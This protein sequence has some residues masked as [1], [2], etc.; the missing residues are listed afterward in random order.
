M[1]TLQPET[2][3]CQG[4]TKVY[5]GKVRAVDS[6]S[7][8][9]PSRGIFSLIGRNGAGKTTLVRILAT[10]LEP[11]SGRA[12]I[13]GM[14]VMNDAKQLRER[15][16]IVPQEARAISWMTPR[17]TVASYLLWRGF[18]Y[19]E[20]K[21]RA[22]EYLGKLGLEQFANRLNGSLSGGTKRK[23][24]VATVLASEAD[25]VFLDEPTTGLDPVS[26]RELWGTLKQLGSERFT[27]LTT[28]YLEEAEQ[29]AD[30]IGILRDGRLVA[31]GTL[32]ELRSMTEYQYSVRIPPGTGTRVSEG[33]SSVGEDGS[34]QVLLHEDDAFRVS[35]RLLE[36]GVRFSISPV[37]LDD[38]FLG[39]ARQVEEVVD[40]GDEEEEN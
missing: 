1:T 25:I 12:S 3:V 11:T 34:T 15:I 26:R 23:V 31:L 40:R 16:A 2:V 39:L 14:D 29:L 22:D 35:K 32:A 33:E 24:L 38:I 18:G 10:E 37:S 28:H 20:A 8:D 30:R 27:F 21:E 36:E 7:F 19:G 17:Q 13:K 6:V 5:D 9:L 4:V